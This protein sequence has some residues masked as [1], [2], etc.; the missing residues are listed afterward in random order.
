MDETWPWYWGLVTTTALGDKKG[1]AM[2]G[3]GR[4][5]EGRRGEDSRDEFAE[6]GV[7]DGN[8][9]GVLDPFVSIQGVLD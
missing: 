5:R 8:D 6:V 7:G 1:S 3:R 4:G 9:G 2:R